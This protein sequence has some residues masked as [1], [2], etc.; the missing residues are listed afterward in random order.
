MLAFSGARRAV[1]CAVAIQRALSEGALRVRIGLNTGDVISEGDRYFGRT[2]FV[3]SRVAQQARGGEILASELTKAL[4]ADAIGGR[5]LDRGEHELK[6]L[7]GHHRL[8][9]VIWR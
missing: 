8:Y 4:V 3:A 7:R 6:G 5:F 2:V 9:E 1:D